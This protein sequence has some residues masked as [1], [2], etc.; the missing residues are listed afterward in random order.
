MPWSQGG[1][2]NGW[3]GGGGKGNGGNNNG[4]GPWGGNGGGGKGGGGKNNPDLEEMLRK[5]QDRF[6]NVMSGGNGSGDGVSN[7]FMAGMA[8]LG[9]LFI[10]FNFFTVRI[11]PDE[12]GVVLRFGKYANKLE[13]GWHF[14]FPQPIDYIY[15]PKILNQQVTTV[16]VDQLA[17]SLMLTGDGNIVDVNFIVKWRIDKSEE[18]LFNIERPVSTVKEVA[19]SAMRE[20]VGKHP[21]NYILTAEKL[22]AAN[23]V[24]KL[25]QDTLNGYKAGILIEQVNLLKVDPP[26]EVIAA[27]RDVESAKA[28]RE[29]ELNKAT[30]YANRV[31]EEAKGSKEK[32]LEA[33]K[34]YKEK[35]IAE[36]EGQAS[37]FDQIYAQYKL[38]PAVTRKRMYLETMEKVYSKTSKII[39]SGGKNNG[40]VVPYLPLGE[41]GKKPDQGGR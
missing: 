32:I 19:E 10:L 12:E 37:R 41:L 21:I 20:V 3:K 23:A 28:D 7:L 4:D 35:S 6:K 13:P 8:L 18:Y 31:L 16:G 22:K 26:S 5:S 11:Q 29:T 38:A 9:I 39:L 36:A 15:K 2:G 30:A 14:R 27:F 25:I 34:A 1:G 24:H 40:G 33:A 17:E